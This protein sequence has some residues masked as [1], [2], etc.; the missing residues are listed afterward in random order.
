MSVDFLCS[1]L[2]DE[3][4]SIFNHNNFLQQRYIL[5]EA[6]IVYI[7]LDAWGGIHHI[8]FPD[9]KL[10]WNFHLHLSPCSRHLPISEE[11]DY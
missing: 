4:T 1:F 11:N 10:H 8:K 2:V 6:S 7:F 5:L 3:L 9:N